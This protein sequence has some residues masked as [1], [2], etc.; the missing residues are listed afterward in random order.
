M[1]GMASESSGSK[2]LRRA[3]PYAPALAV[4]AVLFVMTTRLVLARAGGPAVPLDDSYIHFQ[5]ARSVAE[6]HPF[7]YTPGAAPTPGATSLLWPLVLSPFYAIGFRGASIIWVAWAFGFTTLAFLAVETKR[8]ADG[9]VSPSVALCAGAMVLAFGGN[10][11]F[12]ASGMEVVPFAW[13]FT[14]TVRRSA[15]WSE[16]LCDGAAIG[17]KE[18][19]Y[20]ELL[21]L[22]ALTPL[23]RPEGA[24]AS[25]IVFAAL[26][27]EPR[28][29][30]LFALPALGGPL[31]PSLVG[32]LATGQ[33]VASTAVAK[34]LPLNPYYRGARLVS[35]VTGNV[36]LFFG[37]LCDG[38]LWTSTFL[39]EGGHLIAVLALG[40]IFVRAARTGKIPRAL[41]VLVFALCA[42]IPAT[43]ETF[44]V[45][46]VR[47]IWPFASGWF[48]GIAALA[49]ILG[50]ASDAALGAV[51][52]PV[53]G[54]SVL[55]AGT[56]VG[57]FASR[58]SPSMDDLADSARAVT[59]QQVE[60]A[61]WVGESLPADARIGVN[62]T[63]AMA[64]FGGHA[65][66]D[67]V[68]LTTR[69]EAHYWTAG[70][71]SRF[72]HYEHLPADQRPTHFVV[73]P[74]WFGVDPLL[75]EE[76]ASRVVRH[77]IL[78]GTTM[79]AYRARYDL[80]SSG[81]SPRDLP[82]A[83]KKLID[84]LDVADLE[85]EAAHRYELYDATSQTDLV[86]AGYDRADG[87]RA[88]RHRDTFVL[89]TAA[90]GTLIARWG[91]EEA[92]TVHVTVDGSSVGTQTL[93][94]SVWQEVAL[95]LPETLA[96]GLHRF[97][98]VAET[99]T[100]VS[101]HYWSMD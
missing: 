52:A 13:L 76:L 28:R 88:A 44:L 5:Y 20:R 75:G 46:R 27:Y 7:R 71:G 57:W 42:L 99:G 54:V 95:H 65:T 2:A 15:E 62:D 32:F 89:R 66:F 73:Y 58:L 8:L 61:K 9:L 18:K 56:M 19:A 39:P 91:S 60:L 83:G 37:T 70:P 31:L 63:G 81:E 84:A 49:E 78:G 3:L 86:I 21:L 74:E 77:S 22:A 38:R 41:G 72:E 79:V 67:V 34:W 69:G 35:A 11:W 80:L 1:A 45:N 36:E 94:G 64:Y 10:T 101:L 43:Y 24:V 4:S 26:M 90:E 82:I 59:M 51:G 93:G 85:D 50:S 48:V 25:L 87:G 55:L 6:L 92:A 23:M 14:R 97:D 47:Y 53:S 33:A 16:R 12:A 40:A 98:V 30:R 17:E 100:F 68:G 29:S 96:A